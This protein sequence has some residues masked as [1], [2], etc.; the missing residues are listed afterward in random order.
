[1][2]QQA[3]D[4][5]NA[6]TNP[7]DELLNAIEEALKEEDRSSA[8]R[9]RFLAEDDARR[10][11]WRIA[12][13]VTTFVELAAV[14]AHRNLHLHFSPVPGATKGFVATLR[15]MPTHPDTGGRILGVRQGPSPMTVLREVIDLARSLDS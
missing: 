9:S 2:S 12:P 8:T 15:R 6:D 1:M 5:I 3:I 7:V 10:F 11:T 13:L 4:F 14:L